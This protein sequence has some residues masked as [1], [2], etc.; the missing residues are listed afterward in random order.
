MP[1][2]PSLPAKK[3]RALLIV[4]VALA[5]VSILVIWEAAQAGEFCSTGPV[6]YC[7]SGGGCTG[8]YRTPFSIG[9]AGS[10]PSNATCGTTSRALYFESVSITATSWTVTTN[11]FGV[12]VLPTAGGAAVTNVVPPSSGSACPANG[13][14]YVTLV[15]AEGAVL[16]CWSGGSVWTSP[17]SGICANPKGASLGSPV[18][19]SGGQTLVVYMYGTGVVPPMAGAYTMQVYGQGCSIVSGSVDL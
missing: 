19:I 1:E 16:A 7:P 14:F 15:D 5:M 12:K 13:G 10:V 18:T 3:D 6:S 17:I 2:T 9:L 8:E 11:M 4:V